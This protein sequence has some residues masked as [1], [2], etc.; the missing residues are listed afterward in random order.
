MNT[1]G[2]VSLNAANGYTGGTTITSGTVVVNAVG[3]MT[4]NSALTMDG[5]TLDL[6]GNNISL[7]SITGTTTGGVIT[8]LGPNNSTSTITFVG[9]NSQDYDLWSAVNDNTNGRKVSISTG[10]TNTQTFGV[11]ARILHFHSTGT[12]TGGTTITSQSIQADANDAFGTGPITVNSNNS[13]T[14]WS[15]VFVG[16]G[17]TIH[18]NITVAQG[19]P[20]PGAGGP[21]GV[22][23]QAGDGSSDSHVFGTVTIQANNFDGGLFQGPTVGSVGYLNIHGP[24]NATGTASTV[25][26]SGGQVKYY[27]GGSY[28]EFVANG[29]AVLAAND[30]LSTSAVIEV[31]DTAAGTL[32]LNGF[33]QTAVALSGSSVNAAAVQNSGAGTNTLTLNTSGSNSYNGT[34]SGNINLTVGGNGTQTISGALSYTGDTKVN[35]GTLSILNPT[36]GLADTADVLV[37]TG[38]LFDLNFA[39][40]D[41]VDA[42]YLGGSPKLAGS[43]WG[44]LLSG[45]PNL[46]N[47]LSG[48]GW[49]QVTT[50]GPALG[51]AGDYNNN[52]IVDAADYALWRNYQ[53]TNTVLPNDPTG[54]TIGATQYN[55]WKANFG[56]TPGS[57]SALRRIDKRSRAGH[58]CAEPSGGVRSGSW[59]SDGGDSRSISIAMSQKMNFRTEPGRIFRRL[60]TSLVPNSEGFAEFVARWWAIRLR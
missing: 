7:S 32:D 41:T 46:S 49:L 42:L 1:T 53:G 10:I 30:G 48:T 33:N 24:V 45:A 19:K 16:T 31:A 35:S 25:V 56:K 23:Q 52:G 12:Y 9:A 43:I 8:N 57:G 11:P 54:G 17:M 15:Q 40:T 4:A 55:T 5:G 39:G 14:N 51:I 18:N 37:S 36:L 58:R 26:Q 2:T 13:S 22:I 3:A 6:H 28:Q 50:T 29:T 47:L 59:R 38:A 21:A 44:G 20:T 34:V 60:T 27:G